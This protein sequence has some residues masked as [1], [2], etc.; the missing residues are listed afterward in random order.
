MMNCKIL[1]N[2]PA[3]PIMSSELPQ[4]RIDYKELLSFAKY[5]GVRV[6]I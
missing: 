3:H 5:K 1:L 4:V 6:I 2:N